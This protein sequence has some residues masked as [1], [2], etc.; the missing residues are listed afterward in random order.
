MSR[1][2]GPLERGRAER[3]VLPVADVRL[4]T[5]SCGATDAAPVLLVPGYTG[6]KEDFAPLLTPLA[7]AGFRAVAID[8][9]GQFESPGPDDPTAYGVGPLGTVVL[10]AC[11]ALGPGVRLVGHSFGGLVSRAAVLRDP[12]AVDS[13]VLLSSGPAA[14][15]GSRRTLIEMAEPILAEGGVA[16]VYAALQA[17]TPPDPTVGPELAAFLERR[18]LAGSPAMLAGMGMALRSEPDRVAE[19]ATAGV[20]AL[21]VHGVDDDAWS[22]AEQRDM[23]T[24]LGARYEVIP[25]AVHSAAVENPAALLRVLLDFWGD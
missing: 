25:D 3:G 7:D 1:G 18:F 21:V 23:A 22:P 14:L 13:L 11:R 4:A 16:G 24:R 12:A 5:L 9:P 20:R 6:S 17:I 10:A 19:L 8:L 2:A 15:G